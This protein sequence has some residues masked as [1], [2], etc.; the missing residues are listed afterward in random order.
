MTRTT[1]AVC[2]AFVLGL[3]AGGLSVWIIALLDVPRRP[4]GDAKAA[5]CAAPANRSALQ[6][7]AMALG[8]HLSY[9]RACNALVDLADPGLAD[10]PPAAL[11]WPSVILGSTVLASSA[12]AL[13][14]L[15]AARATRTASLTDAVFSAYKSFNQQARKYLNLMETLTGGRPSADD[16]RSSY[17]DLRST[18]SR[19]PESSVPQ[20]TLLET[21][22][23]HLADWPKGP[24]GMPDKASAYAHGA[25]IVLDDLESSLGDIEGSRQHRSRLTTARK[26]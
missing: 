11:E 25:H 22:Y 7:T 9:E 8:P 21:A 3:A 23:K 10:S 6:R 2:A 15:R 20:M 1:K 13:F 26:P 24:A 12:T 5:F 19:I 16:L 14:N 17:E 4:A 18:L